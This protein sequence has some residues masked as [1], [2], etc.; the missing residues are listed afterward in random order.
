MGELTAGV[1]LVVYAEQHREI[2][3]IRR[4]PPQEH[5]AGVEGAF[6]PIRGQ[7]RRGVPHGVETHEDET[8]LLTDGR[9][10]RGA[11]PL[12]IADEDRAGI[13]A[14]GKKH[15]D[16]DGLTTERGELHGLTGIVGPS[17]VE[18]IERECGERRARE[19]WIA[20]GFF[21]DDGA[22]GRGA[23]RGSHRGG[24]TALGIR[25]GRGR[26]RA[27]PRWL[28][29]IACQQ[30]PSCREREQ[31]EENDGKFRFHS[32]IDWAQRKPRFGTT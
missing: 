27:C 17:R 32:E 3:H 9:R 11:D 16:N 24:G 29:G 1:L 18:L 12:E 30:A 28:G 19:Q 2:L 14:A 15:R 4:V 5:P 10:Q 25:H 20:A 22:A 31:S 8:R 6:R 23:F 13:F 7:H 21:L 26:E